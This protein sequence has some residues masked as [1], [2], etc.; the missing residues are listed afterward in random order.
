MAA[1]P[2]PRSLAAVEPRY[3]E[4]SQLVAAPEEDQQNDPVQPGRTL[5]VLGNHGGR[6]TGCLGWP[7]A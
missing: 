4:A 1:G 2:W 3:P 6:G 5:G 7:M